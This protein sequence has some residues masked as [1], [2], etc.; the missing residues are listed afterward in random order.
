MTGNE[1]DSTR[2]ILAYKNA[3]T[4]RRDGRATALALFGSMLGVRVTLRRRT[5][6]RH[7]RARDQ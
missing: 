1:R 6:E 3:N 7:R 2:Q 4:N 5:Y